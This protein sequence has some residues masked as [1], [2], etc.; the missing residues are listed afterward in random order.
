[1]SAPHSQNGTY[2]GSRARAFSFFIRNSGLDLDVI[3]S[4]KSSKNKHSIL[5][6]HC[7]LGILY[8]FRLF[9]TLEITFSETFARLPCSSADSLKSQENMSLKHSACTNYPSRK[10]LCDEYCCIHWKPLVNRKIP[11]SVFATAKYRYDMMY[12]TYKY[13][14]R[15]CKQVLEDFFLRTIS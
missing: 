14:A 15:H 12:Y 9:R 2:K 5:C 4:C 11:P 3:L 8:Q 13:D 6:V 10:I 1:M 7:H